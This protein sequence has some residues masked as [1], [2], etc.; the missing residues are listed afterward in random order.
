MPTP[1]D[2]RREYIDKFVSTM[3]DIWREKLT[4]LRAIRTCSLF[5][6]IT[7]ISPI[8]SDPEA[9]KVFMQF[10]FNQYGHFL[11]RGV[12][13][14]IRRGNGGDIGRAKVR[15]P[16]EW[17]QPKYAGSIHNIREFYAKSFGTEAV[18]IITG[19]LTRKTP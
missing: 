18:A 5:R 1:S 16:K 14:E 13:R 4:R 2:T 6:S 19:T 15:R 8:I 17:F 3:I 7:A 10:S 9:S 12:G 11:Q